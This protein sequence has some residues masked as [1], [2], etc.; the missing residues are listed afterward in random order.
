MRFAR[1]RWYA[2]GFLAFLIGV[3][4]TEKAFGQGTGDIVY[5]SLNLAGAIANS[6]RGS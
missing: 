4:L 6:A 5:A 2:A 1:M 3:P